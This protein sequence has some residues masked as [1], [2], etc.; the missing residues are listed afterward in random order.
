MIVRLKEISKEF[1]SKLDDIETNHPEILDCA[2]SVIVLCRRT[3]HE[4]KGL[5]LQKDFKSI[6]NEIE[7]FKNIKQVTAVPLVYYSELRSFELQFPMAN[8][9]SQKKYIN[10]KIAKLNRFFTQNIDFIQY[11]QQDHSHFDLQYFTREFA[12]PYHIVSSKFYFQDPDFTTARDMLLAKVKAYRKFINYLQNRQNSKTG[13]N[14]YQSETITKKLQWTS[15]KAAL[16]ELVYGLYASGALNGG[17]A[18]IIEIATALQKVFHFD[19]GDFYKIYAEIK[20]RKHSR[21]KFLDRATTNLIS[22]MDD[23]EK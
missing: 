6:E 17:N 22:L 14:N 13:I 3:L 18:D 1:S 10:K 11:I 2:N 16:T 23:S 9:N 20:F 19:L 15:T 5:L 8:A 4:L 21:T 12:E 7:F